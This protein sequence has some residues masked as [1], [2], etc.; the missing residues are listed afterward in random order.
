[1]LYIMW[2]STGD[3]KMNNAR[4]L[5]IRCAAALTETKHVSTP[6]THGPQQMMQS[7]ACLTNC[8]FKMPPPFLQTEVGGTS[9]IFTSVEESFVISHHVTKSTQGQ[10]HSHEQAHKGFVHWPWPMSSDCGQSKRR[11]SGHS[12]RAGH[13]WIHVVKEDTFLFLCAT[14]TQQSPL[15]FL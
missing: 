8:I 7:H 9:E 13:T 4:L 10:F 15:F 12:S 5:L 14:K 6:S 11:A 3:I 2:Y 1:M